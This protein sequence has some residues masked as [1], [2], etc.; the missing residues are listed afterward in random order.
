MKNRSECQQPIGEFNEADDYIFFE[1][2]I[3]AIEN[4]QPGEMIAFTP[5]DAH[6]P[7]I[8]EGPIHKAIFKVRA[9]ESRK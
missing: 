1:D 2:E 8:S 5:D 4:R 9:S 7:L 3:I 6:A